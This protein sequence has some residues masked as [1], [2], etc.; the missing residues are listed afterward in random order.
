MAARR[1]GGG[2]EEEEGERK[3][4]AR[5]RQVPL[6]RVLCA[7]S[8]R[9]GV[10]VALNLGILSFSK[11]GIESHSIAGTDRENATAPPG[12]DLRIPVRESGDVPFVR[13]RLRESASKDG[14]RF[15][16]FSRKRMFRI[17][18]NIQGE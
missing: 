4:L 16:I 18:S 7:Q 14:G 10:E 17:A 13:F 9:V 6:G 12:R 11:V 3:T 15:M 2:G 1:V 8:L 5:T